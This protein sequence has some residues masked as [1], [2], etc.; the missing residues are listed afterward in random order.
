MFSLFRRTNQQLG[1]ILFHEAYR[2]LAMKYFFHLGVQD[3][4]KKMAS[5]QVPG[6]GGEEKSCRKSPFHYISF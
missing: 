4:S 1:K 3:A 5:G 6:G 2:T